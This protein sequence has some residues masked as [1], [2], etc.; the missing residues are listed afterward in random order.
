MTEER[1]QK[2][3][4]RSGLCSRRD[5]DQMIA[6]GR[7][8]VDGRVAEPGTK[9]DVGTARIKVDGRI[10]KAPETLRYLLLYKPRAVM[11][12]CDDP[13]ERK[14][15]LDLVRP[16]VRE[17]VYPVGR[18][19]YHSEGLL[20]LTNDGEL[21]AR[22]THPRFGVIREYLVKIRG[23]LTPPEYRKLMA[24]TSVEGRHVKPKRAQR[25]LKVRGGKATWWRVELSEGRTHEVRELF[26]CAGHHVQRLRRTAIGPLRDD[27]LKPGDFRTISERELASLR[28]V[29]T[30][31][32]RTPTRRPARRKGQ[33]PAKR[34]SAARRRS[35]RKR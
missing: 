14:T 2:I 4:A 31:S 6:D 32:Q 8:T 1:I 7:V 33:G 27:S 3:I 24:G 26:L 15:V 13:E 30:K 9:A 12:T 5:A 19:D 21:A 23:D 35:E 18:L 16:A 10:L 34:N 20:I 25:D 11:T 22:I 29:I 28:R 17:R